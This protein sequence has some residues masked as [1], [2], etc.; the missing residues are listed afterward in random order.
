MADFGKPSLTSRSCWGPKGALCPI[1]LLRY[2]STANLGREQRPPEGSGPF[3]RSGS[4]QREP[5]RAEYQQAFAGQVLET[6]HLVD[7]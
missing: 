2:G 1:A 4:P 7:S 6:M 5:K 3:A